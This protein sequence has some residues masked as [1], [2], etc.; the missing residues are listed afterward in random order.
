MNF[1]AWVGR[2][3]AA[4][5]FFTTTANA[6]A[7][8]DFFMGDKEN[9]LSCGTLPHDQAAAQCVLAA[10]NLTNSSSG[11]SYT[12]DFENQIFHSAWP[13]CD[14]I[15]ISNAHVIRVSSTS[16]SP[17]LL[18]FNGDSKQCSGSYYENR[19]KFTREKFYEAHVHVYDTSRVPKYVSMRT[20]CQI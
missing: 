19:Y 4:C 12:I 5:H 1:G 11:F 16:T 6:L 2:A 14:D 13:Q 8:E 3:D 20:I 17:A 10:E 18:H 9:R 7:D 15:D